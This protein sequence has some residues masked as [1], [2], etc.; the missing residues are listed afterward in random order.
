MVAIQMEQGKTSCE[1]QEN[2]TKKVFQFN[3]A[4]H[5]VEIAEFFYQSDF[6]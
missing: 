2:P 1:K 6:T 4:L 3:K 5:S